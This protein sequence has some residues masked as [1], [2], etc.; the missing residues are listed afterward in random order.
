[1]ES[2]LLVLVAPDSLLESIAEA[3]RIQA[4]KKARAIKTLPEVLRETVHYPY[5][6]VNLLRSSSGLDLR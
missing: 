3:S 4:H 2:G 1:V 6:S 5:C